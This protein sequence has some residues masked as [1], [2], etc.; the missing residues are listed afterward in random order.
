MAPPKKCRVL[1]VQPGTSNFAG[2]ERVV[3]TICT[4]L[5][6]RRGDDF[7]VDVLYTTEHKNF[8]IEPRKYR[9]IK[10]VA[11]SRTHLMR[12]FRETVGGGNYD[13]VVVPQIEPT[14]IC[15]VACLGLAPRLAMH[16]HG[17]PALE[18]S[19]PK[20]KVLFAMLRLVVLR[21]LRCVF[22]T[23]PRQLESFRAMFSSEVPQLWLPNPVRRFPSVAKSAKATSEITFVSVG[24][25]ARQK[26]HD[27]LIDVFKTLHQSRPE[28]RLRLVGHGELEGELRAQID[29]LGL[30][31]L[32]SIQYAPNSPHEA[33]AASDVYVSVSRWEGW[34]LAICEALRF[35]LP[36]VAT[37]C[38]F[39]PSDILVDRRLGRL[40]PLG[41]PG[42][43]LDAMTYYCDHLESEVR[44]SDYRK[45][46]VDRFSVEQVVHVH[47][48]A[49][50][51]SASGEGRA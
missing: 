50:L 11:R 49:L 33:L 8:P 4:E 15:W 43:L 2:I 26:G 10:K 17:N 21:K 38:D 46:Y 34:S 28:V 44:D 42:A 27:V 35:G 36:V 39:G 14:V 19:H 16:L 5:V 12:I 37:D 6:E 7:D 32:V 31:G 48:K 40:V 24:R 9:A 51:Q 20:A 1:Y 41:E 13:L 22:G 25:F 29:R 3:D 18:R 47:A 45:E 23:S 30:T